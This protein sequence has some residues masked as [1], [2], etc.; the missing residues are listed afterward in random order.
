MCNIKSIS[1]QAYLSIQEELWVKLH[2]SGGSIR[3]LCF[4]HRCTGGRRP[5]TRG[6]VCRSDYRSLGREKFV[7]NS[8]A[9]SQQSGVNEHRLERNVNTKVGN[10]MPSG[11]KW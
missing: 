3:S 1:M 5:S 6:Q 7:P 8:A 9:T 10:V 2:L 11:I 4:H